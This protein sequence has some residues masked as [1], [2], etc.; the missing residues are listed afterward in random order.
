MIVLAGIYYPE[1]YMKG[2]ACISVLFSQRIT[3]YS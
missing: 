2:I 3:H 1:G